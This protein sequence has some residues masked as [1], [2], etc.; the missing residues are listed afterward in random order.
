MS[1]IAVDDLVLPALAIT[2]HSYQILG[3]AHNGME[4]LAEALEIAARGEVTSMNEVFPK[5]RVGAAYDKIVAGD[6][7]F[8]AVV[9]Y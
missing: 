9:T 4:Y 2:S 7:R 1:G 8:K 3:S 6:V 5:D